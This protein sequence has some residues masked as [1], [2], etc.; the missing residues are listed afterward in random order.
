MVTTCVQS[1]K[2]PTAYRPRV[3]DEYLGSTEGIL[4]HRNL[5]FTKQ[6]LHTS[7]GNNENSEC[8]ELQKQ[9][10][11]AG[12]T[13]SGSPRHQTV[14]PFPGSTIALSGSI[15]LSKNQDG[16][17]QIKPSPGDAKGANLGSELP[18]LRKGGTMA[19]VL[20]SFAEATLVS[21]IPTAM[22][23]PGQEGVGGTRT[24]C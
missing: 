2:V 19:Q 15:L 14:V 1:G 12:I 11:G 24:Y 21:N 22:A 13:V 9:P 7:P 23:P 16:T 6:H 20:I 10:I 3:P 5:Q 4:F 8:S 17:P 18:I